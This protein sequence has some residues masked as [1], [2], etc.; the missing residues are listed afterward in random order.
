MQFLSLLT[1]AALAAALPQPQT[2][3][4]DPTTGLPTGYYWSV[5]DWQAGCA[6]S[7]CSYNFNVTGVQDGLYPGF[8]AYCNGYDTGFY[9]QCQILNATSTSGIPFVSASLQPSKQDGV[10]KMSV[11]LEFVD[12]ASN[13]KYNISAF[14][15]AT[16]NAF[17][18]PLQD[19]TVTPSVVTKIA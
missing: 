13:I 5:Y 3:T 16:Y 19:F 12:S 9:G 1:T 4:T 2:A 17:V 6:S 14:A 10:A 7:G 8:L 15:D 18:A 11:S